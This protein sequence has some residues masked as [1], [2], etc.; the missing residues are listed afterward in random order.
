MDVESTIQLSLLG[1]ME[2]N[3]AL[4]LQNKQLKQQLEQAEKD[5]AELV[6]AFKFAYENGTFYPAAF[7]EL[8]PAYDKYIAAKHRG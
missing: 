1:C 8:D 2:E 3:S 6:E 7:K 5:K 4:S